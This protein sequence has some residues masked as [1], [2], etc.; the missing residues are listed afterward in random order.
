LEVVRSAAQTVQDRIEAPFEVF[1]TV[2]GQWA[3]TAVTGPAEALDKIMRW[4]TDDPDAI[5]NWQLS[6]DYSSPVTIIARLKPR[7]VPESHRVAHLFRPFPGVPQGIALAAN[8]GTTM[9]ITDAEWLPM[10]AGMPC[11]PCL[12]QALNV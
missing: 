8:C 2:H 3:M 10:W 12:S 6:P 11:E 7:Q 4:C 1:G 9:R 5:V